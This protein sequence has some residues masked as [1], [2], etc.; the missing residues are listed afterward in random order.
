MNGYAT[1]TKLIEKYGYWCERAGYLDAASRTPCPSEEILFDLKEA[2]L[3]VEGH[4]AAISKFRSD[5]LT[6][7][8]RVA[9]QSSMNVFNAALAGIEVG[10]R[11]TPTNPT[12]TE[13]TNGRS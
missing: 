3:A 7:Q 11:E 1:L 12:T 9:Q 8:V 13:E 6:E 4:E 10:K 5:D 2:R